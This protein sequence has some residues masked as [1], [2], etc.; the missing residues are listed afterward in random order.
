LLHQVVC[1]LAYAT[2]A[3]LT[4]VGEV[5]LKLDILVVARQAIV[6]QKPLQEVDLWEEFVLHILHLTLQILENLLSIT[7]P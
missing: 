6:E 7:R 1:F 5:G 3:L 4:A 2:V